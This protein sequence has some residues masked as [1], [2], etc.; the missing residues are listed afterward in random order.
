MNNV[1]EFPRQGAK[2]STGTGGNGGDVRERLA[3][4]EQKVDDMKETVATKNDV[5]Q[6]KVWILS[7]VLGAILVAASIST[8]IVRAFF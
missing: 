2:S 3:R 6:L 7:G 8:L 5:T 4:L 1:E